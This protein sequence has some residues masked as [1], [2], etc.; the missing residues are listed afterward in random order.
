MAKESIQCCCPPPLSARPKG[1]KRDYFCSFLPSTGQKLNPKHL[2]NNTRG[3]KKKEESL[4]WENTKCNL[5]SY[6][7]GSA[8]KYLLKSLGKFIYAAFCQWFTNDYFCVSSVQNYRHLMVFKAKAFIPC[9]TVLFIYR[10]NARKSDLFWL[11]FCIC[12]F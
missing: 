9:L 5:F 4:T 7:Q 3:K 12:C 1:L 2:G 11:I 10:T 8:P 6:G